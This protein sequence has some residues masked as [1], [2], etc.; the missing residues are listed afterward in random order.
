MSKPLIAVAVAITTFAALLTT[1]APSPAANS[2]SIIVPAKVVIAS[3]ST[4]ITAHPAQDCTLSDMVDASWAV[5]PSNFGDQFLFTAASFSSSYTFLSSGDRVGVVRADPTGA[6]SATGAT[7]DLTQNTVTYSVKYATWAYV[8][9]SRAGSVVHVNGLIHQWSSHNLSAPSG[10]RVYLQR[11]H[12]GWQSMVSQA[13]NS[14]GRI[15]F[16]F[17]QRAVVQY[18]L[19]VLETGVEWSGA[20]GSTIL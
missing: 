20:S 10:R 2:C 9:S 4:V 6:S 7:N 16:A 17:I 14:A 12:G 13:T 15:S 11:Y 18:R 8:A 1:A 3:G 5:S 19:V